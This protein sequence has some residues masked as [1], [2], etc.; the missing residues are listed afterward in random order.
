MTLLYQ[1]IAMAD[2]TGVNLDTYLFAARFGNRAFN[3]FEVSTWLGDLDGLH[4][5]VTP[6][7][8]ITEA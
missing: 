4:G 5:R 1:Y 7:R 3:D 8:K 2:P 6:A